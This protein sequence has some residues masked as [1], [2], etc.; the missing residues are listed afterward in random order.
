MTGDSPSLITHAIHAHVLPVLCLVDCT[1]ISSL[2]GRVFTSLEAS[3]L[4]HGLFTSRVFVSQR[5][6]IPPLLSVRLLPLGQG[7]HRM[8]LMLL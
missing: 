1:L 3:P 8:T 7:A 4:T 5:L 2:S 6:E